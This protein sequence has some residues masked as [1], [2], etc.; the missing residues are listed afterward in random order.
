M[1]SY[2]KIHALGKKE[3]EGILSGYIHVEEKVDGSQFRI[4]IDG[5]GIIS[6]AS[7]HV[8]LSNVDSLF[9]L[10]TE[11][12]QNVF[13]GLREEGKIIT[14]FA[15]YL[16]KPKQNQ[17]PYARTPANNFIIFDVI[18]GDKILDREEKERFA[19]NYGCEVVPLL[20][21]GE[22]K[23]FTEDIWKELLTKESC[24]KHQAGYDRIEGL[25][26]KNYKQIFPVPEGHSLYGFFMVAKIVNESFCE[27]KKIKSPR[28]SEIEGLKE[29]LKSKARWEKAYQ[30]LNEKGE[31]KGDASDIGSM[32]RRVMTDI[33]EEETE[34]IKTELYNIF[35]K[36]ILQHSTNG[37]ATWY[38]TEKIK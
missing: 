8:E 4:E 33:K 26:I 37:L 1:R 6:C 12:A 10:G 11:Q 5:Q 31:L 18:I 30:N 19:F 9:K 25:V 16:A 28:G 20:W 7:H 24:L 21:R 15:E 14:I 2:S 34:T 17:I 29:S 27:T 35:I 36:E 22:G 3:V 13:K 23:D 32:I 38:Q